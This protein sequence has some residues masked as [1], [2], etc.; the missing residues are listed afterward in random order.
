MEGRTIYNYVTVMPNG[1]YVAL[2]W[3]ICLKWQIEKSNE[4]RG[5]CLILWGQDWAHSIPIPL[6]YSG[7][8]RWG[9]LG[10]LVRQLEVQSLHWLSNRNNSPPPFLKFPLNLELIP[11][12]PPILP[13][14]PSD[15]EGNKTPYISALT[16]G[17]LRREEVAYRRFLT[18]FSHQA[19]YDS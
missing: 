14:L 2:T 5:R 10:L 9:G 4:S 16:M 13:P 18:P 7:I 3:G 15:S 1:K 12:L 19:V 6:E 17:H 11:H 8:Y